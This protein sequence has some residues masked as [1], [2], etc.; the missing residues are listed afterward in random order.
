[1]AVVVT[2]HLVKNYGR[3]A[4]LRGVSLQVESGEIFG[5]LGQNGAGKTTLIKILLGITRCTSGMAALLDEPAGTASVRR[6]IGYLP[7]DHRFPDYHTGASLMDFYGALQEVPRRERRRRIPQLLEMV[8]LRDRMHSKVRTYSKGMKQRLGIAQSLLNDPRVLFFDEPTDGV[9]PVG[10]RHIRDLMQDLKEQGKTVFLNS[11][12]LG[13]VELVCDRVAILSRGNL[14]RIGDVAT[15]TQLKGLYLIG[16]APGQ[17]FPQEEAVRLGYEVRQAGEL[18]EIGLTDSQNIDPLVSLVV[19][20][21][22]NLRHL[23][24]KRQTLE[25][26]FIAMVEKDEAA[27]SGAWSGAPDQQHDERIRP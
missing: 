24:E 20:R 17:A 3:I 21:G 1:M 5:L 27:S 4:A 18:W 19:D 13:E 10:R 16:L 8:G 15:L 7:E 12:L 11:H 14:V 25:D 2:D 23:V 9:D 22:L 6:Y 26:L